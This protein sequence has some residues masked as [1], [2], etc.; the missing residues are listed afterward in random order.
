MCFTVEGLIHGENQK[1]PNMSFAFI[2]H[3]P[4]LADVFLKKGRGDMIMDKKIIEKLKALDFYFIESLGVPGA[5]KKVYA[6]SI[7]DDN[8]DFG[9]DIVGDKVCFWSDRNSDHRCCIKFSE[10]LIP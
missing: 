6:K 2:I 5:Y 8:S 3:V 4:Y 7:A 9:G 1:A 10:I